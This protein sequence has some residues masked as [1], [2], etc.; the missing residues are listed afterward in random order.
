M[1]LALFGLMGLS[2]GALGIYG[3]LAYAVTQRRQEIG[4]R[5]ALGARPGHVLRLVIG[6]G[7][8]LAMAGV[9][10]GI[11]VALAVTHVMRTLLYEVS[12]TD[13]LTFAIVTAV[14]LS[15]ALLASWLP[16]RRALHVDPVQALHSP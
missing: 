4:I 1:L 3:V 16:A 8:A 15:T 12:T 14:L 9:V 10:L 6:Q 11:L 13:P 7:M 2:L 5:V